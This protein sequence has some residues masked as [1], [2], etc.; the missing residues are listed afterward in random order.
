MIWLLLFLLMVFL[1]FCYLLFAPFSISVSTIT[2][3]AELRF[4]KVAKMQ[5]QHREDALILSI[6]IAWWQKEIN[7]M[8]KAGERARRIEKGNKKTSK[9]KRKMLSISKMLAI[10]QSF[11]IKKCFIT[12]CFDSMSLNGLLYPAFCWLASLSGK[13]ISINF[14]E[15]NEVVLEI[16]NN[17][18][19]ILRAYLS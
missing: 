14:W 3:V 13:N 4:H 16:E 12:L 2:G 6:R 18:F 15:E 5:L 19:R 1:L 9:T 7:F 17:F 10:L 11:K 8:D